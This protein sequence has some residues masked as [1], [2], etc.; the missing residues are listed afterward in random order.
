[1]SD[2]GIVSFSFLINKNLLLNI[3]KAQK[4]VPEEEWDEFMS[5]LR[6]ELPSTFRITG[7]R[8]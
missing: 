4:V 8:R 6:R 7:T 1:M 5:A 2:I 3:F